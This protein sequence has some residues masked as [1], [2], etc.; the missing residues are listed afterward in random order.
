M[1][2]FLDAF[3]LPIL[4]QEDI[5]HLNRFVT[6]NDTEAVIVSNN[7]PRTRWTYCQSLPNLKRRTKPILLKLFQEIERKSLATCARNVLQ[8]NKGYI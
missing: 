7:E 5:N 3:D 8:H 6:S 4:N 2:K 1:D